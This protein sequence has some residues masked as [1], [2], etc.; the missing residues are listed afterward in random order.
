MAKEKLIYKQD[1]VR[2]ESK[3]KYNV[4]VPIPYEF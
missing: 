3:G 4:T 2:K 1:L